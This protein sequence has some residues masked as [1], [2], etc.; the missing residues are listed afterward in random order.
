LIAGAPTTSPSF[1]RRDGSIGEVTRRARVLLTG[2]P[3]DADTPLVLQVSRWDRMKDM[4][5]VMDGF[6]RHVDGIADAHLML[7]GPS[8]AGVAD[9]P[10]G[11]AVLAECMERWHEL[12]LEQ[13]DRVHL[14]C[15]P[16]HDPDENA[17]IVNALQRH[18]AVVAQKSIAEGFGLTVLEA[19]W[20][21]RPVVATRVGG[22][23][24][25]IV[26]GE[27]GLLVDDPLDLAGFG[28]AVRTT[29]EDRS[30]AV[31]LGELARQRVR[32]EFLGD[33]HLE[34]WGELFIAQVS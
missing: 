11:G 31:R 20:K 17:T 27:H 32:T 19:M 34:Q 30:M 3:P 23:A 33:R 14:A 18:A 2:P 21:S 26:D 9:D 13:R 10:E 6:V 8:V 24:D 1:T 4:I 7:A 29:L 16:M 15:L 22:I 25:Q 28:A 5:G 12:P